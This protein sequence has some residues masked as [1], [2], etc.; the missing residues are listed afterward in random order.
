MRKGSFSKPNKRTKTVYS[1]VILL[2]DAIV[3]S[4]YGF[5]KEALFKRL[6]SKDISALIDVFYDDK[7]N[8]E[9][10]CCKHKK[11]NAGIEIVQS[12]YK[13]QGIPLPTQR[14]TQYNK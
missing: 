7:A 10:K 5:S 11:V 8:K 14:V 6:C 9:N 4:L 1:F 13:S 3:S 2:L 12:T